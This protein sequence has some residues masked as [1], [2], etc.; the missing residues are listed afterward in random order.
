M[1]AEC[2]CRRRAWTARKRHS[3]FQDVCDVEVIEAVTQDLPEANTVVRRP[4]DGFDVRPTSYVDDGFCAGERER[5]ARDGRDA[6]AVDRGSFDG[7]RPRR[8]RRT[9]ALVDDS[10]QCG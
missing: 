6:H 9:R 2:Y 5:L 10:D 1:L 4:I 3:S 8:T 7:F